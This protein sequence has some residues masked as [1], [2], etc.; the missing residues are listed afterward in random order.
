MAY[1]AAPQ[2]RPAVAAR[3]GND[4]GDWLSVGAHTPREVLATAYFAYD[5]Q[6]MAEIADVLGR[7]TARSTTS[8]CGPG[9]CAAFNA[10]YV[11]DDGYIEGDTQTVYLLALHMGLLPEELR[12]ARRPSVWSTN[13]ERA[14]AGTSRPASSASGC[15]APCSPSAATATSPTRC[16]TKDT[17]PSWGYSIRHGATTI[18]ER[19]DGWTEDRGFQTPR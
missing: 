11:G 3:R 12:D 9:S 1:L 15:C 8:A 6:L 10:A 4:Y 13:I 18:W 19:W 5:A 16:C 14:T 2:P 7:P 17:F